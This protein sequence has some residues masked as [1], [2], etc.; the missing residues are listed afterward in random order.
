MKGPETTHPADSFRKMFKIQNI[1]S[2]KCWHPTIMRY[3]CYRQMPHEDVRE[4]GMK[5]ELYDDLV[6]WK[7]DPHRKPLILYGARQV[8]KSYIVTEFGKTEYEDLVII[9][10]DK[11]ERI[12]AVFDH[13]FRV[14]QII[15][16]IEIICGRSIVPGRTLLFFDEV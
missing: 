13:G 1:R 11:D 2:E 10:C 5:R 7:N 12:K 6:A 3:T 14:E 8:G 16:D 4:N 15:S 9:N